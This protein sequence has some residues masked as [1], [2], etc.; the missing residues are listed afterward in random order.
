MS[1]HRIQRQ[2]DRLPDDAEATANADDSLVVANK[3]L[4]M[5]PANADAPQLLR[6]AEVSL[7]ASASISTEAHQ[8]TASTE[9]FGSAPEHRGSSWR[10]DNVMSM[11][12]K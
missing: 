12:Q 7:G 10:D 2:I 3:A 1:S 9:G 5:E 6:A 4:A 11:I 8:A